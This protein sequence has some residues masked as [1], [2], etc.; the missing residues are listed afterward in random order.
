M[1]SLLVLS[2]LLFSISSFASDVTISCGTFLSVQKSDLTKFKREVTN[3]KI[4]IEQVDKE[5]NSYY[6][7]ISNGVNLNRNSNESNESFWSRQKL[8]TEHLIY[9]LENKIQTLQEKIKTVKKIQ[10]IECGISG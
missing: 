2:A 3:S 4:T 1:K 9:S 5:N 10:E 7:D 8:D 6:F